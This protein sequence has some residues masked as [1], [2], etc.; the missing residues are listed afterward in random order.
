[1]QCNVHM[2]KKVLTLWSG[3]LGVCDR[4]CVTVAECSVIY[5]YICTYI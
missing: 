5:A 3:W 4:N 2:N 1:M